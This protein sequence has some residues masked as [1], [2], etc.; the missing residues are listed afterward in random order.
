MLS[1]QVLQVKGAAK[2]IIKIMLS[3]RAGIS[4]GM[5]QG[6]KQGEYFFIP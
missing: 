4:A 6:I 1:V 5:C 3:V 2:D